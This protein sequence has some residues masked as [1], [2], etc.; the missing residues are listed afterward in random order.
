M[1]FLR[2]IS[3]RAKLRLMIMLVS[4]LALIL[5]CV[6]FVV[7]ALDYSNTESE[8]E[9]RSLA[10]NVGFSA[11][12]SF[13]ALEINP[14]YAKEEVQAVINRL[15]AD[16]NIL[17]GALYPYPAVT[18]LDPGPGDVDLLAAYRRKGI[19][20][21]PP[22]VAPASGFNSKTF[23]LTSEIRNLDDQIVGKIYLRADLRQRTL[24][25][26]N[27]LIVVAGGVLFASLV[28]VLLAFQIEKLVANPVAELLQTMRLVSGER[29]YAIRATARGK[30]EVGQLV[31]GF[32][33]MLGQVEKR[34]EDLREQQHRLEE[35]VSRRTR[36]LSEANLKLTRS[37]E[38]AEGANRS[39]STFLANMSHELRTPL[40]AIIGYSEILEED[41]TDLGQTELLPDLEKIHRSGKLLLTLINDILDLSKIEAGKMTLSPIQFE[42]V[43][44]TQEICQDIE[45]LAAKNKNRI[46]VRHAWDQ[47]NV[48]TDP[49]RVRQVVNNLLSNACKFT[50]EGEIRVELSAES[51]EGKEYIAVRVTDS[52]IGMTAEQ[53]EKI[54]SP[55]TQADASIAREY[56][57]T[58]LGL[59]ITRKLCQMMGG[60]LK[61]ESRKGKGSVFT[62]RFSKALE[63]VGSTMETEF[64]SRRSRVG[65]SSLALEK[66]KSSTNRPKVLVID[67]DD[68]ARDLLK[69]Q[70]EREG[71]LVWTAGSGSE[72][73]R[74]ARELKPAVITLDVFMPGMTGWE[75]M[76]EVQ[77]DPEIAG[78]PVI[79]VSMLEAHY[80][81][82]AM[83]ASDYLVKPVQAEE[84]IRLVEK[85]AD[86]RAKDRVLIVEDSPEYQKVLGRFLA[87]AGYVSEIAD[88][89]RIGFER[90]KAGEFGLV[91]LDL[92]MPEMDGFEFLDRMKLRSELADVPV[93]IIIAKDL[94]PEDLQRLR[95]HAVSIIEK[96]SEQ[97][98]QW[99]TDLLQKIGEITAEP[100]ATVS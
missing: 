54:F 20:F 46:R 97:T 84:L 39:K 30:D 59:P 79:I 88:N 72:G 17:V 2:D 60:G 24:F 47:Q 92:L 53:V 87:K 71:Y 38:S 78:I 89:G 11:S 86:G 74:L 13:D 61:V 32:N 51:K 69:R 83:G 16:D 49:T 45:P 29:D 62:A 95:G 6:V 67:D 58:G 91:L 31:A 18:E 50:H 82:S 93:V 76:R 85:H 25:I 40:N 80:A 64:P 99:Q 70:L 41:L 34:D 75:F 27:L 15:Q 12:F 26:R 1:N 9:L 96:N 44:M 56:G 100:P 3:I 73:L 94:T 55:F 8:R 63:A 68:S 98:D 10:D 52:G 48:Y 77:A 22:A 42:L 65:G 90:L 19:E 43:S 7:W 14:E 66:L 5:T 35:T 57:G 28:A 36:E 81:G 23:E 4:G 37:K 21:A 33:D